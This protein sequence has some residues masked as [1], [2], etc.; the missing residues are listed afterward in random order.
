ME[1][2]DW[3]SISIIVCDESHRILGQTFLNILEDSGV[4]KE[5]NKKL[6]VD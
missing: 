5:G 2:F 1:R 4:L 3:D 6:L